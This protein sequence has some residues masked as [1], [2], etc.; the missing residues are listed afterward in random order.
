MAKTCKAKKPARNR[1]KG[2]GLE[3]VPLTSLA[4]LG[5]SL[6]SI[7]PPQNGH[8][9]L[10]VKILD[11]LV[12][13]ISP[14][15]SS[16]AYIFDRNPKTPRQI[17]N[18][19][20]HTLNLPFTSPTTHS[21]L[22]ESSR[23]LRLLTITRWIPHIPQLNIAPRVIIPARIWSISLIPWRRLSVRLS[24]RHRSSKRHIFIPSLLCQKLLCSECNR[25]E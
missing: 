21:P 23:F 1:G 12:S 3:W 14:K 24:P 17:L 16:T 6:S 8:P 5:T 18:K 10:K 11:S 25:H 9:P 19:P 20:Y 4:V 15:P 2:T 13:Q 22:Q 7:R